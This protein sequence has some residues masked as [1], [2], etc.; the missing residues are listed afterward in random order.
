M[1]DDNEDDLLAGEYALGTLDLAAREAVDARRVRD[2]AFAAIL[3]AWELRLA[4]LSEGSRPVE[5]PAHLWQAIMGRVASLGGRRTPLQPTDGF[6]VVLLSRQVIRWKRTSAVITALAACMAIWIAAAPY[7]G[8]PSAPTLVAFLQKQDEAPAYLVRA[9]LDS[10]VLSVRPVAAIAPVGK[11]YELWVIDPQLGAPKSLGLL[12]PATSTHALPSTV[13]PD[14][15][16][17]ATYA[18]TEE[19]P[20]GSPSG[21][22]TGPPVFFGHLIPAIQ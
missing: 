7:R 19:A 6:N 1:T 16:Q 8:A 22:P 10:R 14:I 2:L 17:R 5:P 18:V 3:D 4:P 12:D 20:G 9:D 13:S 21:A 11:A 15:L